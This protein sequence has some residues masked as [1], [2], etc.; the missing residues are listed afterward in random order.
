MN[1]KALKSICQMGTKTPEHARSSAR[2]KTR[3]ELLEAYNA[4]PEDFHARLVTGN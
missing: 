1:I 4:N 3:L 2:V